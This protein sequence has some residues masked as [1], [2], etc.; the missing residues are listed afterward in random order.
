M[1]QIRIYMILAAIFIGVVLYYNH[2]VSVI[3]TKLVQAQVSK[4]STK[5]LADSSRVRLASTVLQRDS[6]QSALKVEKETNGHLLATVNLLLHS[7]TITDTVHTPTTIKDSTRTMA[8]HD[9]TSAGILNANITAPP[10]P[11]DLQFNY[12]FT[13][14]PINATVSLVRMQ[15]GEALFAVKYNGGETT[16]NAPYANIPVPEKFFSPYGRALYTVVGSNKFVEAEL[17]A[18]L[19]L[20][21]G[22]HLIGALQERVGIVDPGA[23]LFG[24]EWDF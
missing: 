16:I 19:H 8:V 24:G 2:K 10:F 12:S 7:H 13:P 1:K 21:N 20:F 18:R 11:T 5:I 9:S 6:A 22:F 23:V 3:E 14:A 4:D 15:D 17:G